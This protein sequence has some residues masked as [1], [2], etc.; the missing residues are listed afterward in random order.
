[1]FIWMSI[2][3]AMP[4]A[5]VSVLLLVVPPAVLASSHG[6]SQDQI[7]AAVRRS[8]HSRQV[9][10]TVNICNTRRHPHMLGIRGQLPALGFPARLYMRI[11]VDYWVQAKRKFMPDSHARQSIALGTQSR[12]RHQ[13]GFIWKF[14]PPATLRGRVTFEWRLGRK[15]I[16]RTTRVTVRGIKNVDDSDPKGYSAATCRILKGA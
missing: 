15:V 7:R 8:E 11:Q 6:P 3:V 12:G 16:G 1:M 9:W 5:A 14:A 2:R 4:W 13:A 10:A